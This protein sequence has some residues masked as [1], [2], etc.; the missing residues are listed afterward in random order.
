MRMPFRVRRMLRA[1]LAGGILL[2]SV[3]LGGCG[4]SKP[5]LVATL[6]LKKDGTHFT[7]TVLRRDGNTITMSGSG[8]EARTFLY[9]ELADIS[10]GTPDTAPATS[11]SGS[12]AASNAPISASATGT[13]SAP[14]SVPVGGP[15]RF[16]VGT[17]F[18]VRSLGVIDSCCSPAGA[19]SLGVLDAAVKSADGR[20]T[21]P[22]GASV[23]IL[24]RGQKIADNRVQMELE[25]G[26]ADFDG[27]HYQILSAQSALEPGA[28]V[29]LIGPQLGS[30]EA[31][32]H[33]LNVH[34]EDQAYLAFKASTPTLLAPSQ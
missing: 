17:V 4:D 30:K 13:H 12:S 3:W 7:G 5:P 29:T 14:A 9:A 25:L 10:Y 27:H 31:K 16:A 23:T 24:V 11:R 34:I 8:G 28:V 26:S 21:M 18:P 33:P 6:T 32:I 1:V 22:E 2:L 15:V 20:I 19:I